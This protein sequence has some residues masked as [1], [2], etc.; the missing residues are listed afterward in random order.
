M[1]PLPFTSTWS[2]SRHKRHQAAATG[3]KEGPQSRRILRMHNLSLTPTWSPG[4]SGRLATPAAMQ[5]QDKG[6]CRGARRGAA[7][8]HPC[9]A[10]TSTSR[11]LLT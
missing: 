11:C 7:P 4:R 6:H 9:H 1:R 3:L 10:A 2:A 8:Q 5:V